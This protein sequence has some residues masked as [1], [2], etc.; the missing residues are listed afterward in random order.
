[1]MSGTDPS[2]PAVCFAEAT[3]LVV[4]QQLELFIKCNRIFSFSK[5]FWI[6]S[7][8]QWFTSCSAHFPPVVHI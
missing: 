7:Y 4:N 8:V 1:M 2:L 3:V 6:N 5:C